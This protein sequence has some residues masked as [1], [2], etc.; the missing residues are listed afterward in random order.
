MNDT[1]KKALEAL[2]DKIADIAEVVN[3]NAEDVNRVTKEINDALNRHADVV[4]CNAQALKDVTEGLNRFIDK[5]F[6]EHAI[7]ISVVAALGVTVIACGAGLIT[8]NKRVSK[9]ENNMSEENQE[10]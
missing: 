8:L 3:H 7:A 1:E 6:K 2:E 4:D 10:N 9:L 5:I